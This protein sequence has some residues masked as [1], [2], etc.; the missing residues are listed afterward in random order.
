MGGFLGFG[1]AFLTALR[2]GG[3]DVS[4]ALLRA[5]VAMLFGAGLMKLF[6]HIAHSASRDARMEK[7]KE[8]LKQPPESEAAGQPPNADAQKASKQKAG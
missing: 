5:S 2:T 8:A 6:I 7:R 4:G 1:G 3:D